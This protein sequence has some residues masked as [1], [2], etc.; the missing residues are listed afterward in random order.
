MLDPDF[1]LRMVQYLA[2]QHWFALETANE[3]SDKPWN[4]ALAVQSLGELR[5][6][7][8]GPRNQPA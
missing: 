7:R 4:L 3:D 1:G 2:E 5:N 6:L 8:R